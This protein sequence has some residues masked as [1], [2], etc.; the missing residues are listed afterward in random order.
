MGAWKQTLIKL[1][2]LSLFSRFKGTYHWLLLSVDTHAHIY[3]AYYFHSY[4]KLISAQSD[5]SFSS[6]FLHLHCIDKRHLQATIKNLG[7]QQTATYWFHKYVQAPFCLTS[8]HEMVCVPNIDSKNEMVLKF[9]SRP[10]DI[11]APPP[12]PTH[13]NTHTPLFLFLFFFFWLLFFSEKH[14]TNKSLNRERKHQL[15]VNNTTLS[16][17]K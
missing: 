2:N 7:R 8:L 9:S 16:K 10:V 6:E 1:F 11:T 14:A 17:L 4:G 12:P 13:T 3:Y 15:R 5:L